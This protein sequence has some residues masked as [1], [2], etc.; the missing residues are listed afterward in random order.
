MTLGMSPFAP[1]RYPTSAKVGIN[2]VVT[3]GSLGA[4]HPTPRNAWGV[5]IIIFFVLVLDIITENV[6]IR[7]A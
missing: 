5:P 3:L 2:G 6:G 7:G 1:P 4:I